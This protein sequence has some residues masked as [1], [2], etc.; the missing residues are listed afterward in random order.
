MPRS[1]LGKMLML[2]AP[3]VELASHGSARAEPP[4]G[5]EGERITA[6][7]LDRYATRWQPNA[8]EPER[9]RF[10]IRRLGT[11][12]PIEQVDCAA[13]GPC[14][15]TSVLGMR[16]C[17]YARVSPGKVVRGLSL[18][19]VG[20]HPGAGWSLSVDGGSSRV[21]V[22]LV[23]GTGPLALRAA[24]KAGRRVVVV[25]TQTRDG[26]CPQTTDH[27]VLFEESDLRAAKDD[28]A[29]RRPPREIVL[30]E[31]EE[32]QPPALRTAKPFHA[33]PVKTLVKAA[34]T[35]AA[36]GMGYLAACWIAHNASVMSSRD[37]PT[38]A[39]ALADDPVLTKLV[40]YARHRHRSTGTF[41]VHAR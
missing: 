12:E 15:L 35:A 26:S 36:A 5:G 19:A 40:P 8:A 17:S 32:D 37:L 3:I 41:A 10:I 33:M 2:A 4:C 39:R 14:E 7:S 18:D 20:E 27:A 16:G 29:A 31:M 6:Y 1:W 25:L 11:D 13:P 34:R 23:R 28:L 30:H 24:M 21:P 9:S 22:F 38:L